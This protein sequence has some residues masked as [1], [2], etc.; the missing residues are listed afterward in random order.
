MKHA[1]SRKSY[2]INT[3]VVG[4]I[5]VSVEAEWFNGINVWFVPLSFAK[6]D[7][8]GLQTILPTM[9]AEYMTLKART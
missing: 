3:N 4:S 2:C 9:Y 5:V 6:C 1:L 8:R 7:T